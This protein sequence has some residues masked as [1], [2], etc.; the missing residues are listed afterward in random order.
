VQHINKERFFLAFKDIFLDIFTY[1]NYKK[2]FKAFRLVPI[3]A[4]VVL[5]CLN[6]QLCT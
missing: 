2:A 6:M 1:N 3:N 5:N 4:Q